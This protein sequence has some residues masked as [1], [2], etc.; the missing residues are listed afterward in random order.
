[1]FRDSTGYF[2]RYRR[3]VD[4]FSHL[5]EERGD[6]VRVVAIENDSTDD[7]WEA[8]NLWGHAS[9]TYLTLVKAHDDCPYWPSV[10][11]RGRWRH[12]AWVCNQ[13][14]DEVD[15]RDDVLLY[16]E[17]DLVWEPATMV[18][19]VDHLANVD[20]VSCPNFADGPGGRYYDI[21]GSRRGGQRFAPWPPYHEDLVGWDGGLMEMDSVASVLAIRADIAR[22]TRFQP[23]DAFVGW[24]R[25][26]CT[27]GGRIWMDMTVHVV[28]P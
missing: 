4:A 16:V 27:Q 8:I 18:T 15:D 17:S 26:I 23:E 2:D 20:A 6:H 19:L 9:F 13:V 22:K 24:C 11:H 1:M 28:H 7:T 12:I 10:D 21:W 25:D 5:M 3:Q 14:L